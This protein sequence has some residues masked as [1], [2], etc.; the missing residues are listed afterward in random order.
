MP[1]QIAAPAQFL[2]HALKHTQAERAVALD[3]D[4]LRVRQP[5]VRVAFE[6]DAFLEVHQIKFDLLRTAPEREICDDDVEQRGLAGT[7]LSCD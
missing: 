2:V 6:L 1:E 5:A 7:G 3:G 4:H